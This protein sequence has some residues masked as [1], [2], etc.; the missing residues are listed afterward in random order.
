MSVLFPSTATVLG[1]TEKEFSDTTVSSA[2]P[3]FVDCAPP[4]GSWQSMWHSGAEALGAL[5]TAAFLV[6]ASVTGS[7]A[8]GGA[9]II[10]LEVD[11]I[12]NDGAFG[13]TSGTNLAALGSWGCRSLDASSAGSL[14]P[15]GVTQA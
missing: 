2:V 10:D 6:F 15:V 13:Q 3:A 5:G 12:L 1:G 14:V 7:G 9:V 4:P 8:A 11:L